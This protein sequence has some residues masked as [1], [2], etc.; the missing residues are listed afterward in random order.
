MHSALDG[1]GWLRDIQGSL[2]IP[3]LMQYLQVRDLIDGV[4]LSNVD[5]VVTWCWCSL[6]LF[7]S[8]SAYEVMF[9]GQAGM[10]GAKQLWEAHAPMEYK[11]LWLASQ[12][13]CWS[14]E[15]LQRH[16]LATKATC[17][18]CS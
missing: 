17:A 13:R 16:G 18:L 15:R 3:I 8:S 9:I 1:N 10:Q 2:I 12:D 6:G 4:H 14:A 11:F 5:D 7:S